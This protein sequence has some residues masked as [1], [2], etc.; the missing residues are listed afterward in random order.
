MRTDDGGPAF[1]RLESLHGNHVRVPDYRAE[2]VGGMSLRDY[3]AG[4]AITG[5]G[6]TPV[7]EVDEAANWAYQMADAMLAE[8]AKER[9]ER[10]KA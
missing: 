4:Q 7:R 6:A 5:I 9:A 1:P 10:G 8:R 3:F 2:S